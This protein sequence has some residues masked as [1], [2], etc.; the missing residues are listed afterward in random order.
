MSAVFDGSNK[1]YPFTLLRQKEPVIIKSVIDTW[2][3]KEANPEKNTQTNILWGIL[4]KDNAT[5]DLQPPPSVSLLSELPSG[6]KYFSRKRKQ[7]GNDRHTHTY[8][9]QLCHSLFWIENKCV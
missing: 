7:K 4:K 1:L 6:T 9:K 8:D 2:K 3:V 5:F